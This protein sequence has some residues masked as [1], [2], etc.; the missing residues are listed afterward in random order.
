MKLL[1][2]QQVN[3]A[4]LVPAIIIFLLKM[5]VPC[6]LCAH[7]LPTE[8]TPLSV[9]S[10]EWLMTERASIGHVHPLGDRL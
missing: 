1:Q 10:R 9:A 5:P 7:I 8:V 4:P 6:T 3:L 2:A